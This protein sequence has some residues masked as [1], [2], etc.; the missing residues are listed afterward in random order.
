MRLECFICHI[1]VCKD[2]PNEGAAGGPP[3]P[4]GLAIGFED[5]A[6]ARGGEHRALRA[7]AAGGG[8]SEGYDMEQYILY[9][10]CI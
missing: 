4:L 2:I 10:D 9:R 6:A 7:A 1:W 5:G 3:G 8:R